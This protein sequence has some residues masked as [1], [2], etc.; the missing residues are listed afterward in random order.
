M[1]GILP[2]SVL[3]IYYYLIGRKGVSI[4]KLVLATLVLGIATAFIGIVLEV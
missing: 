4:A 2:L 3:F 1:P